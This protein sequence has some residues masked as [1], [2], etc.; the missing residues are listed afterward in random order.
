LGV[1]ILS[2][3]AI[4]VAGMHGRLWLSRRGFDFLMAPQKLKLHSLSME[5]KFFKPVKTAYII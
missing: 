4:G 1:P 3:C 2:G 5:F